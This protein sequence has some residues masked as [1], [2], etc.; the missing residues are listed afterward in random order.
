MTIV[1]FLES[2]LVVSARMPHGV[3]LLKALREI[4]AM[5]GDY[6]VIIEPY[7]SKQLHERVLRVLAA[8][9]SDDPD[10]QKEW[11]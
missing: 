8:L 9:Y 4:V 11:A 2:R 3:D 10:Y 1:E 5:G 7:T 6:E